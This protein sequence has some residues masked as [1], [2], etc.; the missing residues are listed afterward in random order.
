MHRDI[1][2]D[3]ILINRKGMVKLTDFGISKQLT[4]EDTGLAKTFVGTLTYMSP[5]RMQGEKYT[6]TG[7]IWSLGIVIVE[8]M[9]GRFPFKETKDFM[10]MLDQIAEQQS[11]NVPNNGHFSEELQDFIS[12]CLMK[13][14]GDRDST[15]QLLAHPWILKHSQ[16][17]ANLPRYF[18]YLN[19]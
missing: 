12:R 17:E 15:H 10:Q 14:P 1:K 8:L 4:G 9:T 6:Y 18:K 11:P 2:P 7:D 5:E 13:N 3:N 16:S 19:S